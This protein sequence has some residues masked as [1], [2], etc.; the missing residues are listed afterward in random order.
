MTTLRKDEMIFLVTKRLKESTLQTASPDLLAKHLLS[1]YDYDL[2][3]V[4]ELAV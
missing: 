3:R 1:H 2:E 4:L